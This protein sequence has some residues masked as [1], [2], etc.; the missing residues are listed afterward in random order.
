MKKYI[1]IFS[2]LIAFSL[3]LSSCDKNDELVIFDV[4]NGQTL[5]QFGQTAAVMPTPPDGVT[6]IEVSVLVTTVSSSDRLVS[7]LVDDTVDNPASSD[8]FTISQITI[9]A[10]SYIGTMTVQSHYDA[11][12]EEGTTFLVIKLTGVESAANP[13]FEKETITIDLFRECPIELSDFVGSWSGDGIWSVFF[14]YPTEIWTSI[15]PATGDLLMNGIGFGWFSGWWGEV[16]IDN[17]SL[18]V[19]MDIETGEFVIEEQYYITSTWNGSLQPT[20]NM[21][22]TGKILN[23]CQKTMEVFP[24]FIQGGSEYD[25][26]N[27][28]G[29]TFVETVYLP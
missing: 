7:I 17:A 11:I 15:D 10:N 4:D 5:A 28:G 21:K 13:V 12:P 23:S 6:Q 20:Y 19:D 9:P 14:G 2:L 25:G 1:K 16:I 8:S 26:V 3:V 29:V 24:I 27:F 18:I 22:A